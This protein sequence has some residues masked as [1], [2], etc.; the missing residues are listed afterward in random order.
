M[1]DKQFTFFSVEKNKL[2]NLKEASLWASQYLNRKISV[3]N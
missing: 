2:V 3:S 1:S